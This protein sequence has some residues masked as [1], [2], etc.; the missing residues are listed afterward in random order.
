ML[1][2][3]AIYLAIESFENMM[4]SPNIPTDEFVASVVSPA[5]KQTNTLSPS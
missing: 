2:L 5:V 1:F 3:S 4:L